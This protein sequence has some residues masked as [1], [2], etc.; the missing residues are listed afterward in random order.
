MLMV[1]GA[2]RA[3]DIVGLRHA[4]MMKLHQDNFVWSILSIRVSVTCTRQ[5]NFIK[6]DGLRFNSEAC[7]EVAAIISSVRLQNRTQI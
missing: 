7:F 3:N 5:C 4:S 6:I 1:K 2:S